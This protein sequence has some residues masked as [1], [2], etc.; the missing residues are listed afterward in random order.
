MSAGSGSTLHRIIIICGL[1]PDLTPGRLKEWQ[2]AQVRRRERKVERKERR[3]NQLY[4]W[5]SN[6]HLLL[7]GQVH[8]LR[9]IYGESHDGRQQ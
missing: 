9:A 4:Q 7:S 8:Y 2:S 3:K 6:Q 1:A 5:D